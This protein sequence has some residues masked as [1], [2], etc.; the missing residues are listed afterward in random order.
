MAMAVNS[1]P[2][3]KERHSRSFRAL[4]KSNG[5]VS[6]QDWNREGIIANDSERSY[7]GEYGSRF[8]SYKTTN[9]H[10]NLLP[11]NDG[12]VKSILA[13]SAAKPLTNSKD[14]V[15]TLEPIKEDS[16]DKMDQALDLGSEPLTESHIQ[17][18]LLTYTYRSGEFPCSQIK[19]P[20]IAGLTMLKSGLK[21]RWVHK[22]LSIRNRLDT[23]QSKMFEFFW[24]S[25]LYLNFWFPK[26]TKFVGYVSARIIKPLKQTR[27]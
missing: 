23:V 16:G 20:D 14:H 11:A 13:D 5:Y 8:S 25:I 18:M 17:E 21:K 27:Y 9:G 24:I 2:R 7:G 3:F 4:Q 15:G 26:I 22:T 6:G 1:K 19:T 10:S 12:S